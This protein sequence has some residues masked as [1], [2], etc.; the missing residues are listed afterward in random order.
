MT[1]DATSPDLLTTT[2]SGHVATV[3]IQRAPNNFLSPTLVAALADKYE[4]LRHEGVRAVVL[5]S[6][7]KNFCAGADLGGEMRE[8][9]AAERLYA[10]VVRLVSTDLP[11]VAAVQGAAVGGGVGLALSADFRVTTPSTRMMLNFVRLGFHHGFGLT[12]LLPRIVGRQAAANLLLTG[13]TVR[14]EELLA[15]GLSDDLV[16]E[17]YIRQRASELAAQ[18]AEGAPAAV[19]SI[20]QT[21]RRDLVDQLAV[22]IRHELSEQDRLRTT[23]D[24]REGVKAARERRQPIFWDR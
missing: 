2:V 14:G 6:A 5:C 11:V 15:L 3:E 7:G 13:R 1:D 10:Q 20:R 12:V 17:R 22:V 8:E 21:L 4:S 24:F 18:L 9:K 19:R 16:E 23:E